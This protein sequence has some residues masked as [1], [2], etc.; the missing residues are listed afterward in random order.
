MKKKIYTK[1]LSTIR[2][3]KKKV[4][5]CFPT[6]V[7]EL[8]ENLKTIRNN[9][10][11]LTAGGSN[12]VFDDEFCRDVINTIRINNFFIDKYDL[13]VG[14]GVLSSFISL[15]SLIVNVDGYEFLHLL[16]GTFGGAIYMNARCYENEISNLDLEIESIKFEEKSKNNLEVYFKKRNSKDCGF[17]YKKSI[18]QNNGEYIFRIRLK[19][20]FKN[21]YQKEI[22]NFISELLKK[23]FINKQKNIKK[24]T[25]LKYF[26]KIY[27]LK[28]IKRFIKKIIKD[29]YFL[30][31]FNQNK[32]L[33]L[34]DF[35]KDREIIYNKMFKIEEDRVKKKHFK[36]CSAGSVF[37]N[38]Y[39]IGKPI[40]KLI[41]EMGY[42][43]F[44]I[45]KISISPY[46]GNII[47]NLNNGSSRDLEKLIKLLK[48][49]V[50]KKYDFTPEEEIIIFK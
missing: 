48:N 4:N 8:I 1:Y 10:G 38:N 2:I 9:K 42:K 47:I 39:K 26:Y 43:G 40:G 3:G 22:F 32:K 23:Y 27:S 45:N 36:Y 44:K 11:V 35:L 50:N 7:G 5:V 14:T 20:Y 21:D 16:P 31:K 15:I 33:K 13:V 6:N 49:E 19:N 46:H 30:E 29:K 18:Y 17:D 12:V 24:I 34:K 37:K 41:D 28:N 25:N